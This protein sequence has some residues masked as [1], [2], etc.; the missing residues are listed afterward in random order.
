M[1]DDF[2]EGPVSL[3]HGSDSKGT[4]TLAEPSK[5][6]LFLFGAT[7]TILFFAV[8][9]GFSRLVGTIQFPPA[10]LV[11]ELFARWSHN[12]EYD[13]LLFWRLRPGSTIQRDM[14][15]SLGLRGPEVTD[16]TADEFRVLSLGESTTFGWKVP[17]ELCYSA[18]LETRL[19]AHGNARIINAGLPG[20]SVFQGR[21]FLEH[22]GLALSPDAVLLYFGVNDFLNVA[23][24]QERDSRAGTTSRGLTDRQ[25]FVSRQR[26]AVKTADWLYARSNAVRWIGWLAHQA[27]DPAASS[28][29]EV[30][31]HPTLP[32]VPE[33]DR[34]ASLSDI[35][36]ICRENDIELIIIVPWYRDFE[37]HAL[38]LR[39]FAD[40]SGVPMV[41]LQ[42]SLQHLSSRKSEFF[43]D[44][45]HPSA[46]GHHVIAD[47]IW[48]VIG[49]P[50]STALTH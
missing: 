50:W 26:W 24:R 30:Q 31:A 44:G 22:R 2:S 47:E 13:P 45:S 28:P 32:R 46:E 23:F 11:S 8:L 38:L 27:A 33:E 35:L 10:P 6:K 17:Y 12:H 36:D 29:N 19:R 37:G 43:I 5:G 49:A 20:Y 42:A 39:R 40:E 48:K 4:D 3:A 18:Q 16:K 21:V 14:I 1:T 25:L 41:D 7:T 34:W 15:N 9:E